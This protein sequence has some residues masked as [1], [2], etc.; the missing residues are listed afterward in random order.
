MCAWPDVGC[1]GV[2]AVQTLAL[3]KLSR[4]SPPLRRHWFHDRCRG[5]RSTPWVSCHPCSRSLRPS[6]SFRPSLSRRLCRWNL[7]DRP[8]LLFL[9]NIL[10]NQGRVG[11]RSYGTCLRANKPPGEQCH[12]SCSGETMAFPFRRSKA[13]EIQPS[14][15]CDRSGSKCSTQDLPACDSDMRCWQHLVGSG[16]DP[17]RRLPADPHRQQ[18]DHR[19]VG[20]IK[21]AAQPPR[22]SSRGQDPASYCY[23]GGRIVNADD[24]KFHAVASR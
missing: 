3:T 19:I 13:T 7:P 8:S 14:R 20:R 11:E 21:R 6:W 15:H 9:R 4:I 12:H 18:A 2:C 22:Q 24:G 16:R 23:W 10:G 5:T 1:A 17:V